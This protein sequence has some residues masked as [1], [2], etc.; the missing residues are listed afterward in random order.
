MYYP[1]KLIERRKELKMNQSELARAIGISRQSYSAW[2]KGSSQPN[3]DNLE[4]LDKILR[5]PTGFLT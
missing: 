4:K 2:E 1:E 3:K 5:F